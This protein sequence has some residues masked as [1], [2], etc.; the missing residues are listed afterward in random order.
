MSIEV[1]SLS[2]SYYHRKKNTTA[3]QVLNDVSFA[4]LPGELLAVVGPNGVGKSTLFRCMLGILHGYTGQIEIEG[5]ALQSLSA[6]A[7][8][9]KIA[10]VPQSHSP[11][12]NYSV[13][14]MVLMGT[15]AQMGPFSSPGE[16][17]KETAQQALEMLGIQHLATRAFL[18][19]SGGERQLVLI[20][21]AIA[22]KAKVIIMDEPTANL[23]Y[24]NQIRVLGK[25]KELAQSGYTIIQSTHSPDHAF[26][27]ANRVLALKDG[28][29]AA[30]GPPA[31]VLTP[32]LISSLYNVEVQVEA[33]GSSFGCVPVLPKQGE[34]E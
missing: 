18:R 32:Q 13:Q 19:I 14:D 8:A 23:D 3:P 24:G 17:Q 20:A 16:P 2:F 9:R 31:Q 4:A 7:L 5:E 21:R 33:M 26:W 22:Q 15:T 1:K 10:Y 6:E 29:V 28:R 11:S 27:F 12:F 34:R 30:L 25:V